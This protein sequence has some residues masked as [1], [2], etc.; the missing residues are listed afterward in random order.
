MRIAH[1]DFE[2]S[3]SLRMSLKRGLARQAVLH[4]ARAEADVAKITALCSDLRPNPKAIARHLDRLRRMPGVVRAVPGRG[5]L[6]LVL[7]HVRDMVSRAEGEEMFSE[8]TLFYT[9]LT[10]RP[11]RNGVGFTLARTS[12]SLHA[13]ERLV[14]RSSV[15]LDR[16]LLPALDT[17]AAAALAALARSEVM[18][19]AGNHYLRARAAG[20]WAGSLD[21]SALE[22]DW[23]LSFG[24]P[25]G[26][27]VVLSVR[28]FLGPDEMRPTLWCRWQG[29]PALTYGA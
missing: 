9:R 7:R 11:G 22:P 1:A 10:A 28:T 19:E 6:T 2:G 18:E 17:E 4:G 12:F 16:P 29:D 3:Q 5:E 13:M 26:R 24:A 23:G 8:T 20:L 27:I 21:L 25:E 14:E 15:A